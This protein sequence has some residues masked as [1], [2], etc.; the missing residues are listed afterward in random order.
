MPVSDWKTAAHGLPVAQEVVP[1]A[2]LRIEKT[3]LKR[4]IDARASSEIARSEKHTIAYQDTSLDTFAIGFSPADW[5][6]SPNKASVT[7][8]AANCQRSRLDD[9]FASVCRHIE[10]CARGD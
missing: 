3:P 5:A 7:E 9:L 6:F 10:D 2:T 4:T 8:A 1:S